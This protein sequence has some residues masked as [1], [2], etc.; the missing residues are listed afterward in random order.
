[1]K[2]I[3]G[4]DHIDEGEV[5][6]ENEDITNGKNFFKRST[7]GSL[8][9]TPNFPLDYTVSQVLD[10]QLR[11]MNVDVDKKYLDMIMDTIEVTSIKNKKVKKLSLGWRQKVGI[12]RAMYNYPQLLLLDEPFNGLDITSVRLLKKLLRLMAKQGMC[13]FISS[14]IIDE[15]KSVSDELFVIKKGKVSLIPMKELDEIDLRS[16]YLRQFEENG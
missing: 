1:M 12:V 5:I 8:I 11:M 13:I 7:I 2:C 9:E 3:L 16:Y 4:L 14:H 10:E 15:L 6:F